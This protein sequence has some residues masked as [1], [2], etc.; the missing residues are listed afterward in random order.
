MRAWRGE[1]TDRGPQGSP[2]PSSSPHLWSMIYIFSNARV[3][4]RN[5]GSGTEK[6][7]AWT[8]QETS[9]GPWLRVV[10]ERSMRLGHADW[11]AG[12][13]TG[14]NVKGNRHAP[15]KRNEALIKETTKKHR[16]EGEGNPRQANNRAQEGRNEGR[17]KRERLR[18]TTS[19][20]IIL[21][22]AQSTRPTLHPP[23]QLVAFDRIPRPKSV[24]M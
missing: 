14:R 9:R 5:R 8:E 24:V 6:G 2:L 17:G 3:E 20:R 13:K 12:T 18:K 4:Y 23:V 22:D 11:R 16:I 1:E 19:D 7:S 21:R 10:P 15:A